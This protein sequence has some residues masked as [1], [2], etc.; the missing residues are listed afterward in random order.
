[1]R[2]A[3]V[4]GLVGCGR[5]GFDSGAFQSDRS[6]TRQASVAHRSDAASAFSSVGL[7]DIPNFEADPEIAADGHRLYYMAKDNHIWAI[8]RCE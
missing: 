4:I 3:V 8:S 1:M 5:L 7:I 2:L 6:G